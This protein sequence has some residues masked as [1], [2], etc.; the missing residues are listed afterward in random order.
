M[1]DEEFI[2]LINASAEVVNKPVDFS[3][4]LYYNKETNKPI[5]YSM[6]ELEGDFVE[7]SKEQY[8]QGR[9]DVVVK[10]NT[11][12]SITNMQYVR[13]LVPNAEGVACHKTN[14]L[15]VDKTSSARWKIKTKEL[16]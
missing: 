13:K 7:V 12:V 9:Y 14:V 6:E 5:A 10:N 8:H 2:K 4:R 15:I 16:S 11:L 3:Y 1:L